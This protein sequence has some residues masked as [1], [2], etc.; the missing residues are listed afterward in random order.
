MG[1]KKSLADF[2]YE[3]KRFGKKSIKRIF[4]VLKGILLCIFIIFGCVVFLLSNLVLFVAAPVWMPLVFIFNPAMLARKIGKPA[5]NDPVEFFLEGRHAAVG[6]FGWFFKWLGLRSWCPRK[7]R[8]AFLEAFT[9]GLK[10]YPVKVQVQY[11]E[12]CSYKE[13]NFKCLTEEARI[14]ILEKLLEADEYGTIIG[15]MDSYSPQEKGELLRSLIVALQEFKG[16]THTEKQYIFKV[17]ASRYSAKDFNLSML[18]ES[19]IEYLWNVSS[20]M[21]ML[22]LDRKGMSMEYLQRL[23][24]NENMPMYEGFKILD[25]Y[26]EN[27]TLSSK[28]MS[29]LLKEAIH[30]GRIAD[31]VAKI[32]IK[33]GLTPRLMAEVYATNNPAFIGKIVELQN[34]FTDCQMVKGVADLN[35]PYLER[36]RENSMRWSAYC[37]QRQISAV[38]QK[39]MSYER[40]RGFKASGQRL[41]AEALEW[42]IVNLTDKIYFKTIIRDEFEKLDNKLKTLISTE[43][44]KEGILVDLTAEKSGN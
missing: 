6:A 43:S 12:D 41:C 34:I 17:I 15:H 27:M 16:A 4:M 36:E 5:S 3:A 8:F 33:H 44:W 26:I 1:T 10:D 18:T 38:A 37:K 13:N 23:V 24:K 11:W 42:L 32:I 22:V 40:Y 39:E 2:C 7:Q 35:L 30:G 29:Y 19:E 21:K 25:K 20:S 14:A 31:I 28:H 9:P